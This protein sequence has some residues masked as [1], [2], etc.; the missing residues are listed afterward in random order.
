MEII[1]SNRRNSVGKEKEN[2]R[3]TMHETTYQAIHKEKHEV[4]VHTTIDDK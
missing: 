2:Q 1:M 4:D 3:V